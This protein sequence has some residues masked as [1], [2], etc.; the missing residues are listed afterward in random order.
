LATKKAEWLT[1]VA[2][3]GRKLGGNAGWFATVPTRFGGIIIE[4]SLAG[5]RKQAQEIADKLGKQ[6]RFDAVAGG[7]LPI[8]AQ[9]KVRNA[10][11]AR[12]LA[13]DAQVK[14]QRLLKGAVVALIDAGLSTRDAAVVLELSHQRVH[15]LFEEHRKRVRK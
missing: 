7:A 5:L 8:E 14:A 3:P 4:R 15:Q 2:S 1:C 11:A 10:L 9:I 13:G 6:L 12:H